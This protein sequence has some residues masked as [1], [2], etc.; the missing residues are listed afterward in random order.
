LEIRR[1]RPG[2]EHVVEALATPV[3][4]VQWD[5]DYTAT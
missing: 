3:E 2:D 1:L 5:F 4:V